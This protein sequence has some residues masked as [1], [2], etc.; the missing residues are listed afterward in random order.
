[1]GLIAEFW[2]Q[3][4]D[5]ELVDAARAVPDCTITIE[6]NDQ[7]FA[8][9][10]VILIRVVGQSLDAVQTAL[11]HAEYVQDTHAHWRRGLRTLP[12]HLTS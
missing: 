1:M 2:L 11:G 12:D 10:I 6:H 7:T 4:A 9:P 3:S 5:L 8:G